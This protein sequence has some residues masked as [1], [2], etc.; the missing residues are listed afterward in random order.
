M[1]LNALF[2]EVGVINSVEL[3]NIG[4]PLRLESL[5][6]EPWSVGGSDVITGKGVL[7]FFEKV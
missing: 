3:A 4:V 6:A 5:P 2:G 1:V 7:G